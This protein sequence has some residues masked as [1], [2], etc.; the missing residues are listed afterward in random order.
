MNLHWVGRIGV[1][2]FNTYTPEY[3]GGLKGND[4]LR[5]QFLE[6]KDILDQYNNG[7]IGPG[8]CESSPVDELI[9][10]E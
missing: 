8:K 5:Q 9:R 4:T 3:I 2:Q 7:I 1:T 6:L 10:R